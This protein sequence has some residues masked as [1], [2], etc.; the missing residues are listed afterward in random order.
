M[1]DGKDTPT[2]RHRQCS[3]DGCTNKRLARD[4]CGKHWQRWRKHGDPMVGA[5]W[6]LGAECS[7]EGCER[8]PHTRWK[9]DKA[10]CNR[11]WLR[12]YNIG[13]LE[14][15]EKAYASWRVCSAP[16]C[17]KDAR[18][19][20][21]PYCEMH[22]GRIRRNG[23]LECAAVEASPRVASHGY[24]T[25][26][27]PGHPVSHKGGTAYVHRKVLFDCIGD[28]LHSCH[29]CKC[30]I[31]WMAKG[32]RRLVADHL[33]GNKANN[34]PTNLVPSCHNCNSTRGLFQHWVVRHRDDPFLWALYEKAR[35]SYP[36]R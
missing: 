32:K 28:R 1:A 22:Y 11:H 7:V 16:E 35:A 23:T 31:E 13:S 4:Y 26:R 15:R 20:A 14:L 27:A 29:W 19:A 5:A 24:V 18:G 33:D 10:V 6:R 25:M 8:K 34:D 3:I 12:L 9:G 2:N 36:L 21:S 30:E 17:D